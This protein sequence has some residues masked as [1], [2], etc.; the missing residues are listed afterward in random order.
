MPEYK[1]LP[2]FTK[3][4]S[5]RTVIGLPVIHGNV[6]E[7][8]D[9]SWPG[10]FADI[11]VNGRDRA[12]FLWQHNSNDPPV[13]VINYVRE[14]PRTEL[15]PKVLDYAPNATGAVEI[16]RTYLDTPRGNEILIGLTAGAIEEMSYAYE[17]P[18]GGS[19]M[20]EVDDRPVRNIRKVR[21]YD[22][23]DVNHGMNPATVAVKRLP[24]AEHSDSVLAAVKEYTDR[25]EAL[26]SLRA[27]EGR[28]LSGE[29]R[30]RIEEAMEALDGA[31]AALKTLLAATEPKQAVIEPQRDVEVLRRLYLDYQHTL[32]QLNGV[33]FL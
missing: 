8:G 1:T 33:T 26:H 28:V 31:L 29:N 6:D 16:S 9:R 11:K 30:K 2:H 20:E 21:I 4:I 13:A 24:L 12:R 17:I 5:E 14:I 23:S 15:P 27:K 10:S 19:D 25:L 22:F 3:E 7:G 18:P 32:A